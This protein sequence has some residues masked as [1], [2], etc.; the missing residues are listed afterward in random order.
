M[1]ASFIVGGIAGDNLGEISDC[2][3]I[4][5]VSGASLTG[6]IAGKNTLAVMRCYNA[7]TVT[8][9]GIVEQ[10][11]DYVSNCFYLNG[12]CSKKNDFGKCITSEDLSDATFPKISTWDFETV[13]Y[14]GNERPLLIAPDFTQDTN[15][16]IDTDDTDD[17]DE[18]V[19]FTIMGPTDTKLEELERSNLNVHIEFGKKGTYTIIFV[20][21]E[22]GK[23]NNVTCTQLTVP[24][25][26]PDDVDESEIAFP[27]QEYIEIENS[28]F[29]L[30][31]GDKIMLVSDLASMK[32]LCN[33]YTVRE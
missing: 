24:R 23:F 20:H 15:P 11:N 27:L 21:Y 32:P 18:N 9:C 29:K 1:S 25:P 2:Y 4:G 19:T 14:M 13:W 12:S 33:A 3:N 22:D 31:Y 28:P 5:D 16:G 10:N 6:G 7:G 8:G 17:E 30:A 26:Q